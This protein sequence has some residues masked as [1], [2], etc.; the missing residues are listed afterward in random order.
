MGTENHI[1][2]ILAVD[3]GTVT[4]TALLLDQVQGEYRLVAIGEAP[5]TWAAPGGVAAGVRHAV[6]GISETGG[7][8]FFDEDGVLIS[9][10]GRGQ[11]GVDAFACTVSASEPL[12]IALGGLGKELSIASAKR[13][14]AGTYSKITATLNDNDGTPLDDQ[15][16]ARAIRDAEPDVVCIAGGVESGADRPVL[17]MVK[18]ATVACSMMDPH[19][20]PTLL[21]A[22]NSRLRRRV[23]EIVGNEAELRVVENV[24]PTLEEEYLVD[25]QREL[26]SLFVQRKLRQLRGV[27]TLSEWSAVPAAPTARAFGRLI[28]YLWY[29]GEPE[30]G[31]VGVD[32]GGSNTTIA[33]VFDEHL[34]LT[35]HSGLGAAMGG[36]QL[37]ERYG[38]EAL[39]RWLPHPLSDSE[40]RELLI[41]KQ[42]H[43]AS[44]PQVNPEL[45]L[46]QAV[47]REAIRGTLEIAHPGWQPGA[48]GA[49][50]ELM[51][52][53]D[54]IV[55]GGGVLA[56]APRPGQAALILLDALQPIGICTLVLDA[57]GLVPALG[58][59]ARIKPVA[60]VEALD[61]GGL[62]NLCTVVAPVGEARPGEIVLK[63]KVSYDDDSE[64][65]VEVP[66]GELEILPLPLGQEAVLDLS[67]R[68]GFDV[69][70]G[71]R[72]RRGR[73][74]VS[75]GL[76]GLIIDARGRPLRLPPEPDQ[77]REKMRQW[78]SD[79]GGGP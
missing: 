43:P 57:H 7:Q 11:L 54:T 9:P 23:A 20:R 70:V 28:D 67:P 56:K 69:G 26:E 63:M 77:R 52:L 50:P 48:A 12:Q 73:R 25:A 31:V 42:S 58:N 71:G 35:I 47:A 19:A 6:D 30:R 32:V 36:G 72:G 10:Q 21:Y 8:R 38:L 24:R 61:G 66:Y 76:A 62:T 13:A 78:L 75:G 2:P 4:T 37:I 40:A 68:R 79:A 16:C 17:R 49:Y 41:N 44:I 5:T 14:A 29:L 46:E 64:L 34:S 45:W 33:A 39:I 55:V 60:A 18:A 27:E 74:R 51:P 53:C 1:G 59:V 3:C 15:A 65:D 22:G